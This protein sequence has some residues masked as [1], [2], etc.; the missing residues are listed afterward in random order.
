MIFWR[1]GESFIHLLH[2]N[3]LLLDVGFIFLCL[4]LFVCLSKTLAKLIVGG[5]GGGL[6][7]VFL[8]FI[9]CISL[10]ELFACVSK[11]LAKLIVGEEE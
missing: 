1:E 11:T 2:V 10:L 6:V 5:G 8:E 9:C 4:E 7:V 3:M